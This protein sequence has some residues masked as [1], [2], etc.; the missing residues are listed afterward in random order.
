MTGKKKRILFC[1]DAHFLYSGYGKYG[2][3]ILNRLA[4]TNKYEL[5]ELACF[6]AIGDQRDMHA[7]WMYY[8]NA[9]PTNHPLY[10]EYKSNDQNKFGGWRFERVALDFKPDIVVDIRDPWMLSF[11]EMSPYRRFYN[12]TIMPTVDSAPQQPQWL[13]TFLD[14]DGVFTYSDFGTQT[15][16]NESGNKINVLGTAPPGVD[17]NTF[18]PVRDK[19]AHRKSMGF[20]EDCNIIG[21][22]MRNQ[23]RKLYPD[24]FETFKKFVDKCYQEGNKE[25]AD[26]TFLYVHCSYPDQGWEIPELLNEHEL[27][28]KV[29]FTYICRKCDKPFCSFFR[30]ARTVCPSCNNISA[31][32]PNTTA[33]LSPYQLSK[34][35]NTFDVY[36]QY[37]VCEG[38]GMPQVEAAACGV[39]V[40]AVDYS[41]M[42]DVIKKTNGLPI[43]VERMFRDP[44]TFA[45]RALPDNDACAD[46]IYNFFKKPEAIRRRLGN[47]ARKGV[48]QFYTWDNTAKIWE[49]Y[50]DNVKL[51]GD[52]GR[53]D[54]PMTK[55]SRIP[56]IPNTP[57]SNDEYIDWLMEFV[58]QEPERI[59]T[60]FAFRYLR[61]L[62]YGGKS[63]GKDFVKVTRQ[64]LYKMFATYCQRKVQCELLR[65]KNYDLSKL[66]FIAY[67]HARA[68]YIK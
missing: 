20:F 42:E 4:D 10:S 60:R 41:A 65:T 19:R 6:A 3:E 12:W 21:T 50:F 61:E 17:I 47:K 49:N 2:N 24:L 57:M 27:G 59:N 11:E 68:D 34:I 18:R 22:I 37:S 55:F 32:L 38:F 7:R 58:L 31:G 67:A 25:L 39:P 33:G 16:I 46:Q 29:I 56:P 51:T 40:M 35:L 28:R 15:L 36:I 44:G 14:A 62:N 63:V 54:A 23:P 30:D 66:D 48:E 53:W 5:A 8:P 26:K 52:Q 13:S 45:Y 64:S 1:N 43:K 9:V